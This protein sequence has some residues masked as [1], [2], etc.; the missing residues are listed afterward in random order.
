MKIK[1]I[2]FLMAVIFAFVSCND[3]TDPVLPQYKASEL[4]HPDNNTLYELKQANAAETMLTLDWKAYR[5]N[6]LM[7]GAVT[8]WIQVDTVGNN[9]ANAQTLQQVAAVNEDAEFTNYTAS[10]NVEEV[11]KILVNS[12][13]FPVGSVSSLEIRVITH[14]GNI[15]VPSSAS[16]VFQARVIPYKAVDTSSLYMIGADFGNWDWASPGIVS[17]VPVNGVDGAFWCINYFTAKNGFKWAPK[18]AWGDDFAE[19]ASKSGYTVADGNAFVPADGLYMVYVDYTAGKITIAPAKV[20]GMGDC[21][22]GW[23]ADKFLFTNDGKTTSILTTGA[24]ELR[25]YAGLPEGVKGSDWWTREFI[26]LDGK[27]S[28]RGRGGDQDRVKVEAGKTVTLDF[29]AGNGTIK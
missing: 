12:L 18:K 9:F 17:M 16:N 7:V 1:N 19:L 14:I 6:D 23:D 26:I 29:K 25:M 24:G 15:L 10:L 8:Y 4:T 20:Y 28:Y 22:G 27:I 2:L 13:G 3:D 21:F 5:Q 11:N